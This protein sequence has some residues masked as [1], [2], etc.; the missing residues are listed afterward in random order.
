MKFEHIAINV[1]EPRAM[2]NWYT[3]HIGL[4]IIRQEK[5]PPYTTF[6]ADDSGN[7]MLEIYKNP[8]DDIPD[9]WQMDP[10]LLH[11]AFVSTQ[12]GQDMNRL[13]EAGAKL[14]VDERLDANS[15]VIMMRDPWGVPIQLC[16]RGSS[17]LSNY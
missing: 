9:Y 14:I 17:M 7:M 13:M 16:K 6:L 10:L 12:P 5:E 3:N 1:P 2:T 11:L 15:R 4:Q 8:P